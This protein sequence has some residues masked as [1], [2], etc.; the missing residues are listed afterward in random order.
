MVKHI[1][2]FFF[3]NYFGDHYWYREKNN[4]SIFSFNFFF[5]LR[6]KI[7]FRVLVVDFTVFVLLIIKHNFAS[8]DIS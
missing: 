2:L 4:Q 6:F 1:F 8:K 3:N 7:E 5:R